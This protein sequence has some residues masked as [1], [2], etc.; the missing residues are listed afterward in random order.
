VSIAIYDTEASVLLVPPGAAI[1]TDTTYPAC[2]AQAHL[3]GSAAWWLLV[4][5]S[6]AGGSYSFHLEASDV[7][8]GPFVIV[9]RLDWPAGKVGAHQLALGASASAAR[10]LTQ[11]S[12]VR[13]LRVR[14]LVGGAGPSVT[15]RSWLGKPT[16][17]GP[18]LASRSYHLD[19]LSV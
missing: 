9:A 1:T 15:F 12:R 19:N 3:L 2:L 5:T 18:G 8:A 11:S 14:A 16:D 17:G 10:L 6:A 13:Y 7:Q 4:S